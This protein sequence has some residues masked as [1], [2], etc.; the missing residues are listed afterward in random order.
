MQ[1]LKRQ[2]HMEVQRLNGGRRRFTKTAA[3]QTDTGDAGVVGYVGD[4]EDLSFVVT[5][6]LSTC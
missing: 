3:Y 4:V 5:A 1:N 6:S 2:T